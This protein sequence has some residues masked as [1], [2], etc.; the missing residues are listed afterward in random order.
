[1]SQ[2]P[3]QSQL[4]L[5]AEQV[6]SMSP[7]TTLEDALLDLAKTGSLE[8]TMN[9]IF[10]GQF[11]E[12]TERDLSLV[13][14]KECSSLPNDCMRTPNQRQFCQSNNVILISDT[15]LV[16][17]P[18]KRYNIEPSPT[19]RANYTKL[20]DLAHS[21]LVDS[22]L[23]PDS[24]PRNFTPQHNTQ[25]DRD[26]IFEGSPQLTP[27]QPPVCQSQKTNR[28]TS[29]DRDVVTVLDS[30]DSS[31]SD[32]IDR[33]NSLRK[34]DSGFKKNLKE[35]SQRVES[36]PKTKH[37][38]RE[39][40][41]SES[42]QGS[43]NVFDHTKAHLKIIASDSFDSDE[44]DTDWSDLLRIIPSKKRE[45]ASSE[46]D[47]ME[48]TR[49][50]KR[51]SKT[52]S[53]ENSDKEIQSRLK[54]AEKERKKV[55][56]QLSKDAAALERKASAA[57][58]A[59]NKIRSKA[60]CSQEI[61]AEF[62]GEWA[63]SLIKNHCIE[64]LKAVGIQTRLVSHTTA[65]PTITWERQT[66]RKWNSD[67]SSWE[68]CSLIVSR[69]AFAL[70]L[71]T[72]KE[73]AELCVGT[74]LSK[75][76]QS[77]VLAFPGSRIIYLIEDLD[78][79]YKSRLRTHQSHYTRQIRSALVSANQSRDTTAGADIPADSLSNNASDAPSSQSSQPRSFIHASVSDGIPSRQTVDEHLARL[80][81]FSKG[82]C[83]INSTRA[84]ETSLWIV[85]FSE[86]IALSAEHEHRATETINMRFGDKVKSGKSATESWNRMLQQISQVT[87]GK[88]AAICERYPTFRKLMSAYEHCESVAIAEHLLVGIKVAATG[89]AIGAGL[90]KRIYSVLCS[91]D[92]TELVP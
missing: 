85:S 71:L 68:P 3:S 26:I 67:I 76:F 70:V 58:H 35:I 82:R 91:T 57:W 65:N 42:S 60:E 45:L 20:A 41:E 19:R 53:I 89:H 73:V 50:V 51:L 44:E 77:M 80:H 21:F 52:T 22:A 30:S 24:A 16:S 63:N 31:D 69:E 18:T 8:R 84:S 29:Q 75:H 34:R 78:A 13:V 55:E 9:R 83:L 88:A 92:S 28:N 14:M 23:W 2:K 46:I 43:R 48:R 62:S 64:S 61:T 47:T 5:W 11:L 37:I 36:H 74:D 81:F 66:N 38:L 15:P 6:L 40:T 49:A 90:S 79:F 33:D 4:Q 17:T 1:M 59:S 32:T 87:C 39:D 54:N 10:D 27:R 25:C 12:G 72:G 7:D 56:K 86:Q